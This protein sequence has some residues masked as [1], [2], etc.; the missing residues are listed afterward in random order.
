VG[1]LPEVSYTALG[2]SHTLA[3]RVND[4]H[5]AAVEE[6]HASEADIV[7]QTSNATTV[8]GSGSVVNTTNNVNNNNWAINIMQKAEEQVRSL[9]RAC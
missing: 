7:N 8:F 9:V 4:L 5:P 6:Q 1:L 2:T 3:I